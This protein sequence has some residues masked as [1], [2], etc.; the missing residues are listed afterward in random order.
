MTNMRSRL[1]GRVI[2]GN[3]NNSKCSN[4]ELQRGSNEAVCEFKLTKS[5][6]LLVKYGVCYVVL[7]KAT[8][9][10]QFLQWSETV[11]QQLQQL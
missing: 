1:P 10:I 6:T 3:M 11:V 4:E 5:Y 8:E 9:P 2:E 7:C